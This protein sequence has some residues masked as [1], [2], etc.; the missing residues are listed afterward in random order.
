MDLIAA[1]IDALFTEAVLGGLGSHDDRTA[2]MKREDKYPPLYT[3]TRHKALHDTHPP[4]R[5]DWR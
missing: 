2:M 3:Y 4:H 1:Q 5:T